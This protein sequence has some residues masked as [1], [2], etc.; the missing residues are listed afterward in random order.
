[1][2]VKTLTKSEIRRLDMMNQREEIIPQCKKSGNKEETC[3]RIVNDRIHCTAYIKHE[4]MW[5]LGLCAL[6]TNVIEM[7]KKPQEKIRFGQQ[8][9]LHKKRNR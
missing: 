5:K 9:Q 2:G 8:K 6:A 4:I 7:E 3:S 1:M